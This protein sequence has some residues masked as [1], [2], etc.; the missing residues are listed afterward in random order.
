[1]NNRYQ[2]I[3]IDAETA[4]TLVN[5]EADCVLA[6]T[7]SAAGNAHTVKLLHKANLGMIADCFHGI[8]DIQRDISNVIDDSILAATGR[9]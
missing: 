2:I 9:R 7:K 1:M 4:E 6:V 3:I 8:S 5:C